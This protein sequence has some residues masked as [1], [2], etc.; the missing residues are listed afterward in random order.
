MTDHRLR[1]LDTG[2]EF[3]LAGQMFIGRDEDCEISLEDPEVSRRHAVISVTEEGVVIAD[4]GST[5]GLMVGGRSSRRATL[6]HGQVVRIGETELCFLE[7]GRTDDPTVAP[8]AAAAP[9]SYVIDQGAGN[10][11]AYRGGY[12]PLPG[13]APD[14]SPQKSERTAADPADTAL[15]RQLIA[16]HG[17]SA[18]KTPAALMPLAGEKGGIYPLAESDGPEWLLGRGNHCEVVLDDSS[19]STEHARLSYQDGVWVLEDLDS[20]NGTR[21][22][23]RHIVRAELSPGELIQLGNFMLLFDVIES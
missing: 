6:A 11:T 5:N 8:P 7:R 10:D 12:A 3:A 14:P 4:N 2:E 19:V 20:R 21:C 16:H 9:A 22:G 15:M 13:D 23:G 18:A 17:L 1:R